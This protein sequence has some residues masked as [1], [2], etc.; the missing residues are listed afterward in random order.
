[1]KLKN[2][3]IEAQLKISASYWN[4]LRKIEQDFIL[5]RYEKDS[6]SYCK[7]VI[8]AARKQLPSF[9]KIYG[10]GIVEK[11]GKKYKFTGL[12]TKRFQ[13]IK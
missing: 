5:D 3:L 10:Y 2:I 7:S 1:M 12:D 11:D 6:L 13:E 8:S 4:S 9:D